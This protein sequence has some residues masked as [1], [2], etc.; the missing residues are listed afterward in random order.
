M[1]KFQ[2]SRLQISFFA[3]LIWTLI[4]VVLLIFFNQSLGYQLSVF[5]VFGHLVALVV[6]AYLNDQSDKSLTVFYV[7]D[8]VST[9]EVV[10]KG[11]TLSKIPTLN[12]D[13]EGFRLEGRL[14]SS[15][16]KE[17]PSSSSVYVASRKTTPSRFE[18]APTPVAKPISQPTPVVVQS[19]PSSGEPIKEFKLNELRL[20]SFNSR[21]KYYS[22]NEVEPGTYVEVTPNH[23]YV[24]R[25]VI[26]S[27]NPL[28]N[29]INSENH[30]IKLEPTEKSLI[31]IS[32]TD[33]KDYLKKTPGS[34]V[35]P[36]YYFEVDTQ[37]HALENVIFT[38]NRLPPSAAKGHRWV[39][40][41][42]RKIV[43]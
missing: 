14:I 26:S 28:P 6:L 33:A 10:T 17:K 37:D 3:T 22:Q 5:L 4:L 13:F 34:I 1:G 8:L 16:G 21:K 42:P 23:Y 39:K 18:P 29:V 32:G 36:G 43:S 35:S 24:N 38:E 12:P 41:Q 31:I 2:F 40:I 9:K 11:S 30:Y 27:G 19:K 20:A 25:L 15:M 7:V